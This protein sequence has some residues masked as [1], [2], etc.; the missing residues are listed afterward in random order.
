MILDRIAPTFLARRSIIPEHLLADIPSQ[1]HVAPQY[2]QHRPL[3]KGEAQ[4]ERR[5]LLGPL[6]LC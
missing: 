1:R 5:R 6:A 3:V 2:V 4:R